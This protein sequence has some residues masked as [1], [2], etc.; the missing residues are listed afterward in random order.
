MKTTEDAM[1]GSLHPLVSWWRKSSGWSH[2]NDSPREAVSEGKLAEDAWN[3]A[4][5][6]ASGCIV[7]DGNPMAALGRI[8]RLRYEP[9]NGHPQ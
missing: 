8:K 9:T 2:G 5:D 7:E 3:A 6:A 4:I 1:P